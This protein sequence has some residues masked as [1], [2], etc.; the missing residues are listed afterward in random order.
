[1]FNNRGESLKSDQKLFYAILDATAGRDS[2]IIF[3]GEGFFI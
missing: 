2:V 3:T 1:M